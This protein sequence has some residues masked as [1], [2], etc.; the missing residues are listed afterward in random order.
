M[1]FACQ[2]FMQKWDDAVVP[3]YPDWANLSHRSHGHILAPPGSNERAFGSALRFVSIFKEF[4]LPVLQYAYGIFFPRNP[5]VS[6]TSVR[7]NA[8]IIL[9]TC[10]MVCNYVGTRDCVMS[11]AFYFLGK[12]IAISHREKCKSQIKISLSMECYII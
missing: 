1:E 10:T 5:L 2:F 11:V 8:E 3:T 4:R 9:S 12:D 7:S 6:T